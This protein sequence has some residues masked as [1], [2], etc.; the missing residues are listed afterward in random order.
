MGVR[1]TEEEAW[2]FVAAS[3]T[4]VLT[5]LRRDGRPVSLPLWFVAFEG[6]VYFRTPASSMKVRRARRD[7]RACFL[8]ESGRAWRELKAVV[9]DGEVDVIE[10]ETL[11]RRVGEELARKYAGLGP[12]LGKAPDATRR[13]YGGGGAILR[14]RPSGS[15]TWDNAKLRF[16]EEAKA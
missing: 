2:R 3:H 8:V 4:G 11:A 13:H 16:R 14:F 5:T 9:M 10:D 7:P 15:I 6:A 12:E 1:L